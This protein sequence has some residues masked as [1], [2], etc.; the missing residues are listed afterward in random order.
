[1]G[2]VFAK[3]PNPHTHQGQD[4]LGALS[5]RSSKAI[6]CVRMLNQQKM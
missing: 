6:F 5:D 2:Q 1:M 3:A 4:S